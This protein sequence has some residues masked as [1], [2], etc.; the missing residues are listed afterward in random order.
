MA[1]GDSRLWRKLGATRDLFVFTY[2]STV[3]DDSLIRSAVVHRGGS[4]AAPSTLEVST[5]AYSSVSVGDNCSLSLTEYGSNLLLGSSSSGARPRFTG[6][7]GRQTVEDI[8]RRQ[9]S[10]YYAA[11]ITAQ[12]PALKKEWTFSAGSSVRDAISTIL[13]PP[14]L[15]ATTVVSLDSTAKYGTLNENLTGTYSDLIG[16][17]TDDLGIQARTTRS[18]SI[19]LLTKEYI[20]RTAEANLANVY[21]IARHQALAPAEWEQANETRPR[22]YKVLFRDAAGTLITGTYGDPADPLAEVIELDM[23]YVRFADDTQPRRTASAL[24]AQEWLSGYSLPRLKVDLLMLFSSG[25]DFDLWQARS[26]L[27]M[28]SGAPVYLSGDWHSNLRGISYAEDITETITPDEWSLEF[29]LK[30]SQEVTGIISPVVPARIW[31]QASYPWMDETR[32][33]GQA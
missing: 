21:P 18:G 14:S 32:E 16:K 13:N 12:H 22:T 3:L 11:S 33:W 5:I 20:S 27:G 8:G 7:L 28:E 15:P 23:S 19:Q 25:K 26:L 6:R 31:A 17:L 4:E 10:N 2:G 29:S 9:F 24:R 30:P 1:K